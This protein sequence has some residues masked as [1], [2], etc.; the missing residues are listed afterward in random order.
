MVGFRCCMLFHLIS[1]LQRSIYPNS[2]SYIYTISYGSYIL[3]ISTFRIRTY[4]LDKSVNGLHPY[5]YIYIY[6]HTHILMLV[7]DIGERKTTLISFSRSFT[8]SLSVVRLFIQVYQQK[9]PNLSRQLIYI[10][11][12]P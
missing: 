11:K 9:R 7:K 8:R 10:L 3:Y 5:I 12:K 1:L 4:M 2:Y 6:A